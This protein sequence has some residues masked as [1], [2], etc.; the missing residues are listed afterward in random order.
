MSQETLRYPTDQVVGVV[1][2]RADLASVVDALH[3]ADVGDERISV[4]RGTVDD[5]DLAPSP[6]DG[7]GPVNS[8]VRVVQK[9]LGDESA[10]LQQLEEA[11]ERG[12]DVVSV[13]LADGDDDAREA[14]KRRIGAA[15]RGC[16]VR[17]V[18][19]YGRMQIEQLD[20]GS[21]T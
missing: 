7:E 18:A 12:H 3:D 17:D 5:A 16:G 20:A 6:G 8:L 11:L 13:A 15:L 2:D 1:P 19:F 10:R 9:A 14:D 4:L 21:T